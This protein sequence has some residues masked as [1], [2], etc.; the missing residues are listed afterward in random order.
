MCSMTKLAE[1]LHR[2]NRMEMDILGVLSEL[3]PATQLPECFQSLENSLPMSHQLHEES[4]FQRIFIF[5][6]TTKSVV[7]CDQKE[8]PLP[9]CAGGSDTWLPTSTSSQAAELGSHPEAGVDCISF[10]FH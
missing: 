10:S 8:T 5:T 9:Q 2:V 1:D 6:K 4:C 7:N 3:V